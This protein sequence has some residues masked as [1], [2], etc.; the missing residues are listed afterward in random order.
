LESIEGLQI[1]PYLYEACGWSHKALWIRFTA[2]SLTSKLLKSKLAP[3]PMH[4]S[5]VA[6]VRSWV[7]G[8]HN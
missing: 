8:S 6:T 1:N 3:Q 5:A 4:Q 2:G 7:T